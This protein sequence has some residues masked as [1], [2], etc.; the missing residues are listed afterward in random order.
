MSVGLLGQ[1]RAEGVLLGGAHVL[2]ANGEF[3][4]DQEPSADENVKTD[5]VPNGA[6]YGSFIRL[7]N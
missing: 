4:D 6:N 2:R 3:L 7:P 1:R 5:R